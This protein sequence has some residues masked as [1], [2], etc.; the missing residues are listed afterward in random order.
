MKTS[1][2]YKVSGEKMT[3]RFGM[4]HKQN[5]DMN[6]GWAKMMGDGPAPQRSLK[7][8]TKRLQKKCQHKRMIGDGWAGPDSGGEGFTCKDCGYSWSCTYY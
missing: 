4:S 7:Y 1:N 6:A 2:G 8:S 3:S 5:R